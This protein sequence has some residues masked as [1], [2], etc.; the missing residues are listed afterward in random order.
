[1]SVSPHKED[2]WPTQNS[3]YISSILISS[4]I[5]SLRYIQ[6]FN[7]Q[8]IHSLSCTHVQVDIS[9][10]SR[11]DQFF[12]GLTRIYKILLIITELLCHKQ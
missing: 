6:P 4:Q 10:Q 3:V 5:S 11:S 7:D 1:M 8:R 12:H 2:K 9:G